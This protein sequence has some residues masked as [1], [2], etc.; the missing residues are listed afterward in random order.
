M[1]SVL[2]SI[3]HIYSRIR[4]YEVLELII[5]ILKNVLSNIYWMKVILIRYF[6][7]MYPRKDEG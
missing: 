6:T 4:T 5:L 1:K 2:I 3:L 7:Y